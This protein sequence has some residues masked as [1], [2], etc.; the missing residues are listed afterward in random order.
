M[1]GI[2]GSEDSKI[3]AFLWNK[4]PFL[5]VPDPRKERFR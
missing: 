5:G 2:N 3:E 1:S 4:W